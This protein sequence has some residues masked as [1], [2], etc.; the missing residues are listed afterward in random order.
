MGIKETLS[1]TS[2]KVLAGAAYPQT[3]IHVIW[4]RLGQREQ[5]KRYRHCR[6]SLSSR[7]DTGLL[8]ITFDVRVLSTEDA[9]AHTHTA[10]RCTYPYTRHQDHALLTVP[11]PPRT[12]GCS[13]APPRRPFWYP[14]S[15][16]NN[17]H[18]GG[19]KNSTRR[20]TSKKTLNSPNRSHHSS[21][22]LQ[23]M[24]QNVP[25]EAKKNRLRTDCTLWRRSSASQ[26]H[27]LLS[28]I[29]FERCFY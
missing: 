2:Q 19:K 22:T 8:Q 4:G 6:L 20:Y 7:Q 24:R 28:L 27:Y 25:W 10:A 14:V 12:A 29:L 11:A 18:R 13:P 3:Y 23:P 15:R 5:A 26:R 9:R 1:N 17:I 16:K 21:R